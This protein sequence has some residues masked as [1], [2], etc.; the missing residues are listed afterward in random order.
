MLQNFTISDPETVERGKTVPR[1]LYL[2]KNNTV[3]IIT[4]LYI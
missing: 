1:A 4:L 3:N 2:L